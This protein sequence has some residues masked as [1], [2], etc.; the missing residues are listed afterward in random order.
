GQT[1]TVVVKTGGT[2]AD[3]P[4]APQIGFAQL[5]LDGATGASLGSAVNTTEGADAVILNTVLPADGTYSIFVSNA[6]G[7]SATNANYQVGVFDATVHTARLVFN[8][9]YLGQIENNFAVDDWTFS[10]TAGQNIRLD[11]L[12]PANPSVQ[13]ALRGPKGSVFESVTADTVAT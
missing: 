1:V 6:P 9:P 3:A 10:G 5:E 7:H 4:L 13:F 2:G 8:Q 11:V 12:D